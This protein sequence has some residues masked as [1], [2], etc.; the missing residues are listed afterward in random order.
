MCG[1]LCLAWLPITVF[2]MDNDI[3]ITAAGGFLGK[4]LVDE[5]RRT[6]PAEPVPVLHCAGLSP[7]NDYTV[8]LAKEKFE[9]RQKYHTVFHLLGGCDDG[10]LDTLNVTCTRNLLDSLEGNPP[11][12]IIYVSSTEVYGAEEGVEINENREPEPTSAAGKS[13]LEAEETL[14]RWCGSRGVCLT[15]L[16][17]PAIVG[18]GMRGMLRRLVNSIYR[19]NYHHIDDETARL[20]V[21]HAV[22]VAHAMVLLQGIAGTFNITDG[23]NPSRH[24][25]IE[26]LACRIGNKRVY[27]LR[28]K[29]AR[30]FARVCEFIPLS[31]YGRKSLA[32]R[33]RTL[34]FDNSRLMR[35]IDMKPTP[36]TDYLKTHDYDSYSL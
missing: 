32:E 6:L 21:V 20:S 16:R 33:Y 2:F 34:T 11:E 3:L 24:D 10:D 28:A 7:F 9:P 15:I 14:R 5:L 27:T 13:K 30:L 36:V 18:T 19:G 8:N 31:G 26:A 29:R 23:V 17:S 12:N 4:Y 22:D 35:A 25:L 1:C